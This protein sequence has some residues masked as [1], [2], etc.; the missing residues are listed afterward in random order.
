MSF[1]NE[2]VTSLSAADRS[3]G[4]NDLPPQRF[5]DAQPEEPKQQ[6]PKLDLAK[7]VDRLQAELDKTKLALAQMN[8]KAQKNWELCL[9]KEADMQNLQKRSQSQI[10]N[11]KKFALERFA[12]ELLQVVDS[13]EQG[14]KHC[15]GDNITAKDVVEGMVLTHKV[16]LDVMEKEGVSQIDPM[17][18]SFNPNFHEAISMVE[19]HDIPANQVVDVIQKGYMLKERLLRPARVV[20]SRAATTDNAASDPAK[21]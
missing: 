6:E 11:A 8:E 21:K 15:E 12:G 16:V 5:D 3:G 17:G 9:R 1:D 19:A 18:T 4:D 20:V 7:E 14:L 13:I 10:D 2:K